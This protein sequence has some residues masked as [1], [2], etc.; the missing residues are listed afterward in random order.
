MLQRGLSSRVAR[1]LLTGGFAVSAGLCLCIMTYLPNSPVKIGF[2]V[3]G[4]ALTN[5]VYPLIFAMVGE[6][7]PTRQR[8]AAL[9]ILSAIFTTAGL[10]APTVMGYAVELGATPEAGFNDGFLITSAILLV[11]GL[12]GLL[13]INPEADRARILQ[14]SA[15]GAVAPIRRVAA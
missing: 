11:A 8:G 3:V 13:I 4:L 12:I 6:I 5:G 2:L 9:S 1:G 15:A 14:R 10:V 7:V